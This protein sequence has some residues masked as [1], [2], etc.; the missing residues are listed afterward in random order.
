MPRQVT[1]LT[2]S[3]IKAAKPREKPY[4]LTD[5]QGLYLDIKPNG[6]KLWRFKYRFAG[7]EK[8]PLSLGAYPD[9]SLVK[10]RQKRA[11]AREQLA[12]GI[13]PGEQRKADRQAQKA[14]G[15]TF[16]MMARE[17][18]AYNSPRWAESTR[19]KANLYLE[20]A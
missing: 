1:P 16:E 2:D 15:L 5:G 13:D 10:A 20:N 8:T 17:W 3:A 9:L 7:T 4:K 18:F 11:E 19:Y 14:S 6:S 12:G